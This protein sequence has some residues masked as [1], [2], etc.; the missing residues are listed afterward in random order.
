MSTLRRISLAVFLSFPPSCSGLLK[1]HSKRPVSGTPNITPV[2]SLIPKIRT[3]LLTGFYSSQH[4]KCKSHKNWCRIFW[5]WMKCTYFEHEWTGKVTN[6]PQSTKKTSCR[7][8]WRLDATERRKWIQQ[9]T[10]PQFVNTCT[11]FFSNVSSALHTEEHKFA[12]G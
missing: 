12:E 8:S 9:L 1:V 2:P 5:A 3:Y 11:F 4:F 7:C 6:S 10:M